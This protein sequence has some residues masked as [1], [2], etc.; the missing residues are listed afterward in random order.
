MQDCNSDDEYLDVPNQEEVDLYCSETEDFNLDDEYLDGYSET[1][2]SNSDDGCLDFPGSEQEEDLYKLML[3]PRSKH[4]I[5]M[6][7]RRNKHVKFSQKKDFKL[8]EHVTYDTWK[9]LTTLPE[10]ESLTKVFEKLNL[11]A[12]CNLDNETVK[13][14]TDFQKILKMVHYY[15]VQ[16]RGEKIQVYCRSIFHT[17]LYEAVKYKAIAQSN[18]ADRA[19]DTYI[20]MLKLEQNINIMLQKNNSILEKNTKTLKKNTK[21]LKKNKITLEKKTKILEHNKTILEHNKTILENNNTFTIL[22]DYIQRHMVAVE[23]VFSVVYQKHSNPIHNNKFMEMV[24]TDLINKLNESQTTYQASHN[25]KNLKIIDA[26]T[27]TEDKA[28]EDKATEDKATEDKATEDT[29]I[30]DTDTPRTPRE[31]AE[32]GIKQTPEP[33]NT[34]QK[35]SPS[36]IKSVRAIVANQR[37]ANHPTCLSFSLLI[38]PS[39]LAKELQCSVDRKLNFEP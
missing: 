27:I 37:R 19:F 30:E 23:E 10:A 11:L 39:S 16:G 17:I 31:I 36:T 33:R 7:H 12:K 15:L 5:F 4:D 13:I 8:S 32:D 20:L 26:T 18:H 28:A 24:I 3:A 6:S 21:T 9:M 35:S 25:F 1:E 29:S 38:T 22:L 2:N 34:P 14:N